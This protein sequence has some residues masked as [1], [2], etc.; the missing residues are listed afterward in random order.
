MNNSPYTIITVFPLS[1]NMSVYGY[2]AWK[3]RH[4]VLCTVNMVCL[5]F[6]IYPPVLFTHSDTLPITVTILQKTNFPL[7]FRYFCLCI[8]TTL[9]IDTSPNYF[10]L[11]ISLYGLSVNSSSSNIAVQTSP[12][13][14]C[15]DI[16]IITSSCICNLH[17]R[18]NRQFCLSRE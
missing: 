6:P 18:A 3:I 17:I 13:G 11:R 10:K 1:N 12:D 16:P 9:Y 15:A 4:F 5:L 2:L 7:W 8:I 14:H